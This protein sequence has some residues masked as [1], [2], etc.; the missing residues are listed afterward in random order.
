MCDCVLL[1]QEDLNRSWKSARPVFHKH[2][3]RDGLSMVGGGLLVLAH[4][5]LSVK[6]SG[7]GSGTM[8]LEPGDTALESWFL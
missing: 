2:M 7:S 8:N 6:P 3:V 4:A 5:T 1:K